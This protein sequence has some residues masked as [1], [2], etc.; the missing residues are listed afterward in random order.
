[1]KLLTS[2]QME[3]E[4]NCGCRSTMYLLEKNDPTFPKPIYLV[5]GSRKG[6]RWIEAEVDAWIEAKA[7]RRAGETAPSLKAD[8]IVSVA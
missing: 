6:K 2:L 8:E 7:A 1:M 4:K 5:E 3:I